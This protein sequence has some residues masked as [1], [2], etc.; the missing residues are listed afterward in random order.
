MRP[1]GSEPCGNSCA[2]SGVVFLP[3]TLSIPHQPAA[4]SPSSNADAR[5]W[6]DSRSSRR[7]L[8]PTMVDSVCEGDGR[9][10]AEIQVPEVG[11][12]HHPKRVVSVVKS[13]LCD[14]GRFLLPTHSTITKSFNNRT[15]CL[16][17]SLEGSPNAPTGD[18]RLLFV[19]GQRRLSA[20]EWWQH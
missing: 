12:L 7:G 11:L 1:R 4:F 18:A 15:Q 10:E 14:S 20:Q 6:D 19:P 16:S 8:D 3:R 9:K 13:H 5:G 2:E 17:C